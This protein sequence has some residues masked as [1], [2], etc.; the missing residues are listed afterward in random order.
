[1]VEELKI[2]LEKQGV[3]LVA[4]SK[5]VDF[6]MIA[7]LYEKGV[8]DFGENK[9][10][11]LRQKQAALKRLDINWHFIGNL[12]SNKINQMI[13][14]RPV[15]WQSCTSL[16]LALKVDSRLSYKLDT[17]LEVNFANEDSKAGCDSKIAYDLYLK[18]QKTCKN[19]NLI[20]IMCIGSQD[21]KALKQSFLACHELFKRLK[22]HGAR[23][24]SMGMSGDYKLAVSCG[25]TMVR[26]GSLLFK[27]EALKA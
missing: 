24:C 12:Q 10:Q 1:M 16:D 21:E 9:V 6:K 14:A 15:L 18:I 13:E 27:N 11:D 23:V 7:K 22:L 3:A 26:L 8:K 5:Y 25:S 19:L 20:G 4:V 2:E 17:L